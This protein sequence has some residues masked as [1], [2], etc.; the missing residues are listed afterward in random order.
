MYPIKVTR[1]VYRKECHECDE[2]F[3]VGWKQFV[4][5]YFWQDFVYICKDCI[6]VYRKIEV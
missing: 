6:G 5:T 1:S 4:K 2:K 3:R